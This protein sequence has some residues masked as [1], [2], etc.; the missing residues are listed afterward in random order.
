MSNELLRTQIHRARAHTLAKHNRIFSSSMFFSLFWFHLAQSRSWSDGNLI[1]FRTQRPECIMNVPSTNAI[2]RSNSNVII[3]FYELREQMHALHCL[4]IETEKRLCRWIFTCGVRT[5]TIPFISLSIFTSVGAAAWRANG[6]AAQAAHTINEAN[7][8]AIPL[9]K[10]Q[11]QQN[12]I[13]LGGDVQTILL[14]T[15]FAPSAHAARHC[16]PICS[17]FIIHFT[18]LCSIVFVAVQKDFREL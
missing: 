12:D 7:V 10:C 2:H 13:I 16:N 6:N 14:L 11:F 4:Q 15:K 18:C 9:A 3:A 1:F 8:A 5:A 17:Y